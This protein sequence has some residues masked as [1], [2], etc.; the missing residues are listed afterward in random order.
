MGEVIEIICLNGNQCFLRRKV[1][2]GFKRIK[3]DENFWLYTKGLG[4]LQISEAEKDRIVKW[5]TPLVGIDKFYYGANGAVQRRKATYEEH[6][7]ILDNEE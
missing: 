6:A 1:I 2:L 4:Q 5:L 7:T 3:N